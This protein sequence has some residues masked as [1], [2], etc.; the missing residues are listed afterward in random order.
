MLDEMKEGGNVDLIIF[1]IVL[2]FYLLFISVVTLY[3]IRKWLQG[4]A[5]DSKELQSRYR[6]KEL[7]K[8][9]KHKTNKIKL[10]QLK[11][12]RNPDFA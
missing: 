11:E 3:D 5:V 6:I 1:L 9:I 12:Q 4:T 7:I 10:I 2:T 8:S